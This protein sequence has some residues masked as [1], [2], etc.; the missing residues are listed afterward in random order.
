MKAFIVYFLSRLTVYKGVLWAFFQRGIVYSLSKYTVRFTLS[1]LNLKHIYQDKTE[2]LE[3][4]S[5]L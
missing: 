2:Q 1:S 5:I 3:Q 4:L